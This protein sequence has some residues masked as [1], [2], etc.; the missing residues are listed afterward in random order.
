MIPHFQH[1][2]SG[3]IVAPPGVATQALEA[4][5]AATAAPSFTLLRRLVRRP[6]IAE[7]LLQE[8]FVDVI[9]HIGAFEG[10]CPL[11]AWIRSLAVN[12]ALMYLRSP[13]HRAV[14]WLGRTG[15]LRSGRAARRRLRAD[16]ALERALMRLPALTRAVVW[17]H[18][19]EGYTH[20]EIAARSAGRRAF[21]NRS[22]RARTC[23]CAS[24][25][26][27]RPRFRGE[28]HADRP[29]R[30]RCPARGPAGWRPT[31]GRLGSRAGSEKQAAVRSGFPLAR[32]PGG[33]N[34]DRCRGP[35]AVARGR[36]PEPAA[37]L[38]TPAIV[39]TNAIR[40]ENARLDELLAALPE[41]SS[42]RGSTAFTIAALEDRLAA[43]DDRLSVTCS[44]RMRRSAPTGC[45]GSAS[46]C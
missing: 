8:T 41:R 10:R 15:R 46:S 33:G 31:G 1:R 42:M 19:V 20:V 39:S 11:P 37:R 22:C 2:D 35:A 25:W 32:D 23:A 27:P 24:F 5:Y 17:L 9:E 36:G 29:E 12:R 18:D 43:V 40:V 30:S 26:R 21:R 13:W 3:R 44:S 45:G 4:V 28:H 6:A 16:P 7:E 38:A 14:D 34:A